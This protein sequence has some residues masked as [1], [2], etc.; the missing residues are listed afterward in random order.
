[1]NLKRLTE[2]EA[3]NFIPANEDSLDYPTEYFT[4]TT[5]EDGW[6]VVK[7]FTGRHKINTRKESE[8]K[9]WVYVLSNPTMP[10]LLKIGYTTNSPEDRASQISRSTGVPLPFK[11]E[12]A[13]KCHEGE[14]F[15]YEVHKALDAYRVNND[16]EFFKIT[17]EEAKSVIETLGQRYS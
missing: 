12:Y 5:T 9:Y 11:V 6:D 1:M 14:F 15:E 2:A 7:Y 4:L 16:R 10:G 13:H 8:G 3:E 17:L